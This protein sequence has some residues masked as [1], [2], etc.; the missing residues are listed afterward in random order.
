MEDSGSRS[1]RRRH[2]GTMHPLRE[3]GAFEGDV[4][5]VRLLLQKGRP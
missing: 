4:G 3:R 2:L 5:A 1:Q